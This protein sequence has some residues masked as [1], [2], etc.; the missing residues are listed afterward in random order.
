LTCAQYFRP[1]RTQIVRIE[2]EQTTLAQESIERLGR[3][4]QR[5][6]EDVAAQRH[7]V[8]AIQ[9]TERN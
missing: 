4:H 3:Y 9:L 7:A 6:T 8:L 2:R 5:E 1:S